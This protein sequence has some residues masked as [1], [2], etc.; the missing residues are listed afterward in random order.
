MVGSVVGFLVLGASV[1][2]ISVVVLDSSIEVVV[3][4]TNGSVG[5]IV[6]FVVGVVPVASVSSMVAVDVLSA[7]V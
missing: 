7:V 3:V 2:P 4:C 5:A 6:F 1:G